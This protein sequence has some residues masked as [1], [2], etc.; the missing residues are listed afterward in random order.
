MGNR[1]EQQLAIADRGGR[2]RRLISVVVGG[3]HVLERRGHE[4]VEKKIPLVAEAP[5]D[6]ESHVSAATV[7]ALEWGC[8]PR[9]A[10]IHDAGFFANRRDLPNR[11]LQAGFR[12][13]GSEDSGCYRSQGDDANVFQEVWIQPSGT[14]TLTSRRGVLEQGR[15]QRFLQEV[16]HIDAKGTILNRVGVPVVPRQPEAQND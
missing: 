5:L 3:T 11:L 9:G 2:L 15:A 12:P 1:G 4:V 8:L 6:Y 7:A 13:H 10:I 16:M 14:I